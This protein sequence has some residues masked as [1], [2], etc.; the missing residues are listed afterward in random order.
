[1]KICSPDQRQLGQLLRDIVISFILAS[2]DTT[3]A[4]LTWFFWLLSS[5]PDVQQ[6]VRQELEAVWASNGKN[7]GDTFSFEELREMHYLHAA[8]S[9][10]LRLYPPVPIDTK[11]CLENDIMPYG[12]FVGKG[13]FVTYHSYAMGRIEAIYGAKT[14]MKSIAAAVI[15]RF[16]MEVQDGENC[17]PQHLRSFTLRMKGGIHVIVTERSNVY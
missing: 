9:K 1:M 14:V 13:W 10:A 4:A 16:E 11:A 8:I 15:E 2:R 12:T 7:V 3:A 6:K 17:P 5:R